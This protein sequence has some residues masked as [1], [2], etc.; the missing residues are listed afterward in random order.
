MRIVLFINNWGGWQIAKWLRKQSEEIVGLVV[1][2][3][4]D[5]RFA[6]QILDALDMRPDLVWR[7]NQLRT[8]ETV[9]AIKE[10]QPDLGISG[11]FGYIL[12]PDLLQVFS[13]G[14]INLHSAYLP[15]NRGWFTNVFPIIDG[16]PAGVTIHF[17]DPGVDTGDLI[18]QRKVAVSPTDTGGS[19]HQKLT[20]GMVD[21]FK[22]TWPLIKSGR[23]VRTPQDHSKATDH[24]R[25]TL[26][27][28]DCIHLDRD[29]RAGDFLNLLRART[30]PPYPSAYFLEDSRRVYLRVRFNGHAPIPHS[31]QF[32]DF[33]SRHTGKD[34][35][36]MLGAWDGQ[37]ERSKAHFT[38]DGKEVGIL[39]QRVSDEDIDTAANPSWTLEG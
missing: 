1:Q 39:L 8:P 3:P 16:S 36:Q 28:M 29:Y 27:Q 26:A 15:W 37:P 18:A 17:I 12:K 14:C 6:R 11:W 33:N 35:L 2:P 5:E 25:E 19:L 24:R 4:S 23:I 32:F 31:S 7:A 20:C 10:L 21:L 34:L 38:V 9:E 30:Y 22:E 13:R